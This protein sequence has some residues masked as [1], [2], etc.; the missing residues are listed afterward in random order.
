MVQKAEEWE[1]SSYQEYV[2]LRR[3][4]LPHYNEVRQQVSTAADYR[5]FV[6]SQDRLV[7][8]YMQSLML[9]E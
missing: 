2:E 8:P 3:G 6:E 1:F 5:N 4:T 9:D 7:Q